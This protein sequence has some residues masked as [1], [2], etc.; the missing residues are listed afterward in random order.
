MHPEI[1]KFWEDAGHVIFS[2]EIYPPNTEP[3]D[4]NTYF[5]IEGGERT[6][7]LIAILLNNGIVKYEINGHFWYS[8]T[9]ALRIIKLKAFH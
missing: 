3:S 6:S 2:I 1:K 7:P 5:F 4:E 9:E 8:E